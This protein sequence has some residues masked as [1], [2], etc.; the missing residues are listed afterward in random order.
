MLNKITYLLTYL[1]HAERDIV[2]PILSVRPSVRLSVQWRYC[3]K[4]NRL[5]VTLY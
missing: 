3:V 4:T 2:L 1:M 5:V